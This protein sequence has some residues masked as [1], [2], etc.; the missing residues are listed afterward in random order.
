MQIATDLTRVMADTLVGFTVEAGAL[1]EADAGQ[2]VVDDLEQY[3][4]AS[5]RLGHAIAATVVTELSLALT[6]VTGM[7]GGAGFPPGDA[8]KLTYIERR[9]LDLL[10]Q[11][12]V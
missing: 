6:L 5:V 1:I 11:R 12:F 10:G 2:N 9:V 8:R 3:D 4:T 7:L